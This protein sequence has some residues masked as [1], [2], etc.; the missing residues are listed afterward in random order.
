[1]THLTDT[2]FWELSKAVLQESPFS[3]NQQSEIHHIG[4]CDECYRVLMATMAV[5]HTTDHLGCFAEHRDTAAAVDPDSQTSDAVIQLVVLDMSALLE[6]LQI[7]TAQWVF[8]APL[9]AASRSGAG[10]ESSL[11]HLED[12]DNTATQLSYDPQK[13]ELTIQIAIRSCSRMPE[14]WLENKNGQRREIQLQ[15]DGRYY[16]AVVSDFLPGTYHIHFKR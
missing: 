9:A 10:S 15:T 16:R 6:Q 11:V 12:I 1:M 8:D 13:R 3:L 2:Q 4:E 7:E 5:M 14:V